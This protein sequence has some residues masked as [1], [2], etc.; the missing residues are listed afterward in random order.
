MFNSVSKFSANGKVIRSIT[1][2]FY[3][4]KFDILPIFF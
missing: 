3:V 1:G 2:I 4:K